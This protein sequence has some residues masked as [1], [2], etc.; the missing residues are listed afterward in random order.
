MTVA[1]PQTCQIKSL[2]ANLFNTTSNRWPRPSQTIIS[3]AYSSF[4]S[5]A[6]VLRNI[7]ITTLFSN[8][9]PANNSQ[10]ALLILI[11]IFLNFVNTMLIPVYITPHSYIVSLADMNADGRKIWPKAEY[12]NELCFFFTCQRV[13]H[14]GSATVATAAAGRRLL[15]RVGRAGGRRA[16]RR[17]GRR[18][19][20]RRRRRCVAAG[21]QA[22][23]LR[24]LRRRRPTVRRTA[25]RRRSNTLLKEINT[26][27]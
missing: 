14:Q 6:N 26:K 20:R 25:R 22:D 5:Y 12:A 10:R 23:R 15:G 1:T 21:R 2:W 4:L 19:R 7:R 27:L 3:S 8:K 24:R 11:L 13:G 16:G 17:D 18:R 9:K